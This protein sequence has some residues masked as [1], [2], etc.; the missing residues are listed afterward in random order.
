MSQARKAA[1]NAHAAARDADKGDQSA[2]FAARS[3][4]HAAATVHVK[5]HAMIASNYAAKQ[6]YYAAEDKKYRK[7]FN[8]KESCS[9]KIS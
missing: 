7:M 1:F 8:K 3:A 9:I 6:M 4:A 5:K 2:I